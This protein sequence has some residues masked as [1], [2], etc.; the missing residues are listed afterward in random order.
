MGLSGKEGSLV[1]SAAPPSSMVILTCHD[2]QQKM[3]GPLPR[4]VF[5]GSAPYLMHSG[6]AIHVVAMWHIM[7]GGI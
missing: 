3:K 5:W 6:G 1:L 4:H 7:I 2:D